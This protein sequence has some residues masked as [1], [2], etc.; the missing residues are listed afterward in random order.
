MAKWNCFRNSS[1]EKE[2]RVPSLFRRMHSATSGQRG[3]YGRSILVLSEIGQCDASTLGFKRPQSTIIVLP[4][5]NLRVRGGNKSAGLH[6]CDRLELKKSYDCDAGEC[7]TRI[8]RY[9]MCRGSR[10]DVFVEWRRLR[11]TVYAYVSRH[12][13]E[14]CTL[15]GESSGMHACMKE[16][17]SA[18]LGVLLHMEGAPCRCFSLYR[19]GTSPQN[20][21]PFPPY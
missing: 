16:Y 3:S 6:G 17:T 10:Q 20:L 13:R 14:P 5:N 19:K 12:Q 4:T 9:A 11:C 18:L 21:Q 7:R 1:A 8:E 2:Q 15:T